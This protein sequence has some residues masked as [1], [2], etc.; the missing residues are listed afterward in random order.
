M[1]HRF[2]VVDLRTVGVVRG[3]V[4][5]A[6]VL[7]GCGSP[8]RSG[9]KPADAGTDGGGD[10]AS[11]HAQEVAGASD[12]DGPTEVVP[13]TDG[14]PDG[15]Q[16]ETADAPDGGPVDLSAVGGSSIDVPSVCQSPLGFASNSMTP[17]MCPGVVLKTATIPFDPNDS[18]WSVL[19]RGCLATYS[20]RSSPDDCRKLCTDLVNATP[21]VRFNEGINDCLLDCSHPQSPVLSV[22]YSDWIC[23]PMPPD[24]G[25][26]PLRPDAGL[27]SAPALGATVDAGEVGSHVQVVLH[28]SYAW[29]NCMPEVPPDPILVTWTVDI[30]GAVGATAQLS[31]ATLTV[32]NSSS[33]VVQDFTANS[34]TI[35][36]A[37]GAGSAQQ[38]K[39]PGSAS[40]VSVCSLCTGASY[41]LDLVFTVDGQSFPVSGTSTFTC[42][43]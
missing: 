30:T 34:P 11:G 19:Y 3:F 7:A 24:G 33:S 39:T 21:A 37:G 8:L 5:A 18:R 6:L 17:S 42:G 28:A 25:S 9:K 43:Y 13:R 12:S 29:A 14:L 31:K 35:P 22:E 15:E 20:P 41:R 36:L 32:S 38:Q 1:Y 26:V 10:S 2:I 27:D 40:P 4:V 23:E 16:K